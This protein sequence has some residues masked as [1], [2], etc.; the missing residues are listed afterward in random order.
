[1]LLLVGSIVGMVAS[2]SR[3]PRLLALVA[4]IFL[5]FAGL[6]RL[7]THIEPKDGTGPHIPPGAGSM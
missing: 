4:V 1:M 7:M 2:N 3:I 5:I 6:W